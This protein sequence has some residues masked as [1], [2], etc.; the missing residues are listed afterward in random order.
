ME[1]IAEKVGEISSEC[2]LSEDDSVSLN[3]SHSVRRIKEEDAS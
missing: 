2:S 3:K 1:E